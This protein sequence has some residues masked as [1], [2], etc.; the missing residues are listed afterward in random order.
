MGLWAQAKGN[1]R[2]T[3]PTWA[4]RVLQAPCGVRPIHVGDTWNPEAP[5]GCTVGPPRQ[6]RIQRE[7]NIW[8]EPGNCSKTKTRKLCDTWCSWVD[9]GFVT[10]P[11][12]NYC[13]AE[14]D[15][16]SRADHVSFVCVAW[17]KL[18]LKCVDLSAGYKN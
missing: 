18:N 1:I 8:T 2:K 14:D 7:E 15:A 16:F 3:E 10:H 11:P 17:V 6:H 4:S 5:T 12:T 9:A 13:H